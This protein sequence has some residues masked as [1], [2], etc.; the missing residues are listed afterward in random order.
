MTHANGRGS[1]SA[2]RAEGSSCRTRQAQPRSRVAR[3][4]YS[5]VRSGPAWRRCRD[6]S[7]VRRAC[8]REVEGTP[9][10][11]LERHRKRRFEPDHLA[12]QRSFHAIGMTHERR[13]QAMLVSMAHVT[14]DSDPGRPSRLRRI[15][16]RA[17]TVAAILLALVGMLAFYVEHTVLDEDGFETISRE[18]IE[19][20]EIRNQV[21]TTA[22]DG[23][24]R[25]STS[26]PRSPNACRRQQQGLAPVLA[27]LARSSADRAAAAALEDRACRRCGWRRRPGPSA[28]L[29]RLLDDETEFIQ[30]EGGTVDPRPASAHARDRRQVVVIGGSPRGCPSPRAGSRSS[31]RASSRR[32]RRSPRSSGSRRLDVAPRARRRR[33]CDLAR[34]RAVVGSS[35]ARSRS[36]SSSW[37]S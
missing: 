3:A 32:L 20:D 25:T 37:G 18:L 33:A 11:A 28:Q 15:G 9:A 19:N 27:G 30:V 26:R 31:K 16:A 17:L 12:Q 23:C 35:C 24:S 6:G 34:A 29:V 7:K 10:L 2:H 1:A 4:P 13:S 21:A 8:L 22:V 5:A 14:H 36:V